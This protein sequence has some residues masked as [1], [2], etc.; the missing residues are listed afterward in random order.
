M[1]V[2]ALVPLTLMLMLRG[3]VKEYDQSPE[4]CQDLASIG[5]SFLLLSFLED[6]D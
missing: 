2:S 4:M 1:E 6:E 5:F 3:I